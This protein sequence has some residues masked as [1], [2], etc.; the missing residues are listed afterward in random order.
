MV[1]VFRCTIKFKYAY[2][3]FESVKFRCEYI[4]LRIAISKVVLEMYVL[5]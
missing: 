1:L 4:H 2:D 5:F 3:I